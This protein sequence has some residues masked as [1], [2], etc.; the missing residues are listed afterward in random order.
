MA[1]RVPASRANM[2]RKYRYRNYIGRK[3][4]TRYESK[5]DRLVAMTSDGSVNELSLH[6]LLKQ[7]NYNCGICGKPME[8]AWDRNKDHIIPLIKGGRHIISNIQWVHRS[9][10]SAKG[11]SASWEINWTYYCQQFNHLTQRVSLEQANT[12]HNYRPALSFSH[13]KNERTH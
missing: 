3:A 7:Q 6:T 8:T 12:C 1:R 13:T 5:R 4:Q 11:S 10:N 2:A 9:C